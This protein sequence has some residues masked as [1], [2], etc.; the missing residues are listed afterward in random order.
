MVDVQW[1]F[2]SIVTASLA[3]FLLRIILGKHLGPDGLGV[4]TLAFTIYLFG[5]Q[6]SAFGISHALTKYVAEFFDDSKKIREYVFSGMI[7]SI[8]TG[9]L[10]AVAL[11]FLAPVIAIYLLKIPELTF[12]IQITAF[13]FPFIAIQK[14]VLGTLNG[15][16]RMRDFAILNVVQNVSIALVSAFLV[17]YYNMGIFGGV[18]GFVIPTIIVSVFSPLIIREYLRFDVTLWNTARIHETTVFGFFVILG[19]SVTYISTYV[20]SFLIA[21][22]LNPTDVGLYAVALLLAQT[23]TLIPSAIRY[24]TGPKISRLY[25]KGDRIGIRNL[26]YSTMKKSF[27]ISA[28]IAGFIA[29]FGQPLISTLFT[30][31]FLPA[32]G[33]LLVLLIGNVIYAPFMA[34]NTTLH[35][36]GKVKIPYRINLICGIFSVVANFLLIPVLGIIGAAIAATV[37]LIVNVTINLLVINKFFP[38]NF[39]S[40]TES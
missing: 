26:F 10:M 4:Y 11:F 25:G 32:Y 2:I 35:S 5:I 8:I 14:A 19:L 29:I 31:Q 30:D 22:F 7:S 40:N 24:V 1:G 15:F 18:V 38:Y 20:G 27:F 13:C 21:Y 33:P 3:H 28:I 36:I 34:V 37:T 12:F 23:L 9:T 17:L 6:F 16:R 39:S